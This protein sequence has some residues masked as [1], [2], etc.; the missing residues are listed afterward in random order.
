M[1]GLTLFRLYIGYGAAD[2][3]C[4]LIFVSFLGI[5]SVPSSIVYLGKISYGLYVFHYGMVKLSLWL[6]SQTMSLRAM[7]MWKIVAV[8][9]LAF[10]C[11]AAL[12][13][14]SYRFLEKPFLHIK[15][16]FAFV[17]SRPAG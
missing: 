2:L 1:P 5:R 12:A 14:V 8:D 9:G 11:C 3:G 15:D 6:L 10:A 13:S 16:R 7:S 17:P 4:V